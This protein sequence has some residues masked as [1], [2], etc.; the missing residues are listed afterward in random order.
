MYEVQYKNITAKTVR[1]L[2]ILLFLS[3][4]EVKRACSHTHTYTELHASSRYT[5][6]LWQLFDYTLGHHRSERQSEHER[7]RERVEEKHETNLNLTAR[8]QKME[9]LGVR[10][11][12]A[13]IK[14]RSDDSVWINNVL[15][16]SFGLYCGPRSKHT[17]S[18]KQSLFLCFCPSMLLSSYLHLILSLSVS[19]LSR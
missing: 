3:G 17:R 13:E 11:G 7:E 1:I 10:G 6:S 15:S 18:V 9:R 16:Y 8:E 14:N 4:H 19:H 2:R 12:K 5:P